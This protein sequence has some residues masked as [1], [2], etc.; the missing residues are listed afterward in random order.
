MLSSGKF[1]VPDSFS[2]AASSLSY[3]QLEWLLAGVNYNNVI[4]L[5]VLKN[6]KNIY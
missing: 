1:T 2:N 6:H 5:P 3:K 4:K